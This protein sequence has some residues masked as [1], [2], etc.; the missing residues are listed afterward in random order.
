QDWTGGNHNYHTEP[1]QL[2][3]ETWISNCDQGANPHINWKESYNEG[4]NVGGEDQPNS[5]EDMNM[6]MENTVET[7][8]KII[9]EET[10][11]GIP[12]TAQ[13]FVNAVKE[14]LS[15]TKYIE[16]K[17]GDEGSDAKIIQKWDINRNQD[18]L[19]YEKRVID[20]DRHTKDVGTMN[21]SASTGLEWEI[22][23]TYQS[24]CTINLKASLLME[25][26]QNG[27]ITQEWGAITDTVSFT[28][29]NA[30]PQLDEN[31]VAVTNQPVGASEDGDEYKLQPRIEIGSGFLDNPAGCSDAEYNVTIKY[32][33]DGNSPWTDHYTYEGVNIGF[34]GVIEQDMYI[35]GQGK[36]GSVYLRFIVTAK[37]EYGGWEKSTETSFSWRYIVELSIS[38]LG[39]GTTDPSPGTHSY[40]YHEDVT[41]EADPDWGWYFEKWMGDVSST[42]STITIE[43]TEDK[44]ITAV[45]SEE[46]GPE[47]Y[48]MEL[49]K[50]QTTLRSFEEGPISFKL[51]NT[52]QEEGLNDLNERARLTEGEGGWWIT[53]DGEKRYWIEVAEE[54]LEV[55]DIRGI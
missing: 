48:T 36:L 11:A 9:V 37:D 25:D 41:V 29:N 22:P 3:L 51:L 6:P 52:L 42:S 49:E 4:T 38:V 28:I 12:I 53:V 27:E 54:K 39:G 30:E 45:F 26:N 23:D 17:Y 24:D 20:E 5:Y 16:E 35:D 8:A 2:K 31:E 43:M 50:D 21:F 46:G 55:Y 33:E 19:V 14:D 40:L 44:S 18:D 13:E 10:P 47:P 32:S 1:T 15:E 34:S 7:T